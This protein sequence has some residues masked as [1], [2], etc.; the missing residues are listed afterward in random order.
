MGNVR[1]IRG[2]VATAG[3]KMMSTGESAPA[4]HLPVINSS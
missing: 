2:I 3:Y 4:C 1:G